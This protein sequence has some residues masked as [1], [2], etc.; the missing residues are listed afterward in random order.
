MA[1][2]NAQI[3][4][5]DI[6]DFT[7]SLSTEY[8]PILVDSAGQLLT[9]ESYTR[10]VKVLAQVGG[11]RNVRPDAVYIDEVEQDIT[12]WIG[13][14]AYSFNVTIDTN[15]GELTSGAIEFKCL[16]DGMTATKTVQ[17]NVISQSASTSNIAA[18]VISYYAD[19]THPSDWPNG[20]PE[21]VEWRRSDVAGELGQYHWTQIR[22]IYNDGTPITTKYKYY[23]IVEKSVDMPITL[24][25][26]KRAT[27]KPAGL[28]ATPSGDIIME[29]LPNGLTVV[30]PAVSNGWSALI[31]DGSA[32]RYVIKQT[33]VKSSSAAEAVFSSNNWSAPELDAQSSFLF[34]RYSDY[35]PP[36]SNAD[37][38]EDSI[39]SDNDFYKYVGIANTVEDSVP[40]YNSSLWKW[41]TNK[42]EDGLPSTLYDIQSS[43]GYIVLN[44]LGAPVTSEVTFAAQKIVGNEAPISLD[45]TFKIVLYKDGVRV[46]KYGTPNTTALY[47]APSVTVDF[48][49]AT[50]KLN[51]NNVHSLKAELRGL[52]GDRLLRT[53]EVAGVVDPAATITLSNTVGQIKNTLQMDASGTS[54]VVQNLNTGLATLQNDL[55]T[56]YSTIQQTA[57]SITAAVGDIN[58]GGTNLKSGTSNT[59]AT[60]STYPSSAG[61]S[62]YEYGDDYPDKWCR[63]TAGDGTSFFRV[64]FNAKLT[65][66]TVYTMSADVKDYLSSIRIGV[67]SPGHGDSFSAY[68]SW[69]NYVQRLSYTFTAQTAD[70]WMCI[71]CERRTGGSGA[72]YFDIRKVKVEEGNK[73]TAWCQSD[74][75]LINSSI[76]ITQDSTRIATPVLDIDVTGSDGDTKIDENGLSTAVG[77]FQTINCPTVVSKTA[78]SNV[79]IT[80]PAGLQS[81]LDAN[82]NGRMLIGSCTITL[83]AD[84]I[85][86]IVIRGVYGNDTS[87][88]IASAS[89]TS[90]SINGQVK[91]VD[92]SVRGLVFNSL[93]FNCNTKEP[94]YIQGSRRISVNSCIINTNNQ[95]GIHMD[96]GSVF[97]LYDTEIY[98]ANNAFYIWTGCVATIL[99]VRG[100]ATNFVTSRGAWIIWVGSRTSGANGAWATMST[101]TNL[102]DV[103]INT[104]MAPQ[105][106]VVITTKT[107]NTS[108]TG[109]LYPSDHWISDSTIRQGYSTLSV[110][111]EKLYGCMWFSGA[112]EVRGKTIKSATLTVTRVSGKGR[113]GTVD[114]SLYTSTTTG[115]S[116]ALTNLTSIGALGSIGNGETKTFNIDPS[117]VAAVANGGCFVFYT[118]ETS[119]IS[120]KQYSPHY[121]HFTNAV[122]EVTY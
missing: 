24:T 74:E 11:N 25:L 109:T 100:T 82:V 99:Y 19:S 9:G 102:S 94:M 107:Y 110:G 56:N 38:H 5:I 54:I 88:T 10:T 119:L 83:A 43:A 98:N 53:I 57:D 95:D 90:H 48:T 68:Q 27:S 60:L 8:I 7:I 78:G 104:G 52:D 93:T 4:L 31:P 92:C 105:P 23:R 51:F 77:S 28:D 14:G 45:G 50:T 41:T 29:T 81:F 71:D 113:S 16:Y 120:G 96:S 117:S 75:E 111:N 84:Q 64:F 59:A 116:G 85:G 67:S 15:E 2:A 22:T 21:D 12:D 76:S 1:F 18:Q 17:W 108:N 35:Y 42:G 20:H 72:F 87:I 3:T 89:G 26:Y 101:P 115:K 121:A 61:V 122:L 30:K 6:T 46:D 62:K 39:K 44:T 69:N 103:T 58:I 97:D 118:G 49:N 114:V 66:G 65:P 33:V 40:D 37:L 32:P 63:C 70:D 86:D 112:S 79:T 91:I 106:P 80:T 36:R 34:K 55:H 73:A 47:N 13:T